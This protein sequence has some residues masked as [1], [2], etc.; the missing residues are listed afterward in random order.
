MLHTWPG[1]FR[2]QDCAITPDGTRLIAADEKGKLHVYNLATY[3]EEYCLPLKSKST[4]V[5]VSRD[6]RYMLVNLAEGQ[7]QLIDIETTDV[8]RRFQGQKQGE[9]VIRSTFGGATENFVVSGSEGNRRFPSEV[10]GFS[11]ADHMHTR[12]PHLHLA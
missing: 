11:S 9:F 2:V 8:V 10:R 7:I 12:L 5:T 4:S 6:S 1:G 3:A